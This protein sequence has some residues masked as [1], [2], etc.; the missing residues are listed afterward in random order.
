MVDSRQ[1]GT[2][3]AYEVQATNPQRTDPPGNGPC[4][5]LSAAQTAALYY[6]RKNSP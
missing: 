1:A 3:Q 2:P 4:A 6:S 5:G